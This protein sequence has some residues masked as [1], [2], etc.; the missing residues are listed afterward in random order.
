MSHDVNIFL[1]CCIIF[2]RSTLILSFHLRLCLPIG[3]LTSDFR[4]KVLYA[5]LISLMCATCLTHLTFLKVIILTIFGEEYKTRSSSLQKFYPTLRSKFPR[6]HI[7]LEHPS[8][9]CFLTKTTE[10]AA[11][12]E[13][14]YCCLLWK[15]FHHQDVLCIPEDHGKFITSRGS[16]RKFLGSR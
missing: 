9:L 11:E 8:L 14:V 5:F 12:N 7:V 1:Y 4:S 13:T 6:Q 16:C 2:I 3:F 15:P 10:D